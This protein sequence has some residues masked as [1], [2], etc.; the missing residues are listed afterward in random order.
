MFTYKTHNFKSQYRD[1]VFARNIKFHNVT[2]VYSD[3][4]QLRIYRNLLH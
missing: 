4:Q 1:L 3:K 2:Y